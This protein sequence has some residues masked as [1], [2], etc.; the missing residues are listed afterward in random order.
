[1][2]RIDHSGFLL[3]LQLCFLLLIH[4]LIALCQVL[5]SHQPP[6]FQNP[7]RRQICMPEITTTRELKR[8]PC[9][10][11]LLGASTNLMRKVPYF[12]MVHD[13]LYSEPLLV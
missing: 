9:R 5:L 8:N 1:M 13:A 4:G 7:Q 3:S 10:H 6:T 2:A 12:S 11:L